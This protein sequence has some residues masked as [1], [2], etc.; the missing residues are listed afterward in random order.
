MRALGLLLATIAT[1]AVV[2]FLAVFLSLELLPEGSILL[3]ILALALAFVV[4]GIVIPA[5]AGW[6]IGGLHV[7]LGVI[8]VPTVSVGQA[9]AYA[10][11]II[12]S[13]A[14]FEEPTSIVLIGLLA[15][16]SSG[17]SYAVHPRE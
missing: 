14:S 6:R 2:S 15:L 5:I 13:G 1:A 11:G 7:R 4:V 8:G 12:A 9:G 10:L 16:V 3:I 17:Y